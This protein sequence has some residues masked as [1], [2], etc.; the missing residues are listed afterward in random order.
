[1]EINKNRNYGVDLLRIIA[2]FMICM[3]HM[4]KR[5]GIIDNTGF[6][7]LEYETAWFFE[8]A[9]I[10]AV[11]IYALISGFIG[12]KSKHTV[13]SYVRLWLTVFFIMLISTIFYQIYDPSTVVWTD[14]VKVFFPVSTRQYWYFSSFTVLFLFL[15]LIKPAI[16]KLSQKSFKWLIISS[17]IFFSLLNTLFYNNTFFDPLWGQNNDPFGLLDG[18]SGIWLIELFL[19]G[20]YFGKYGFPKFLQKKYGLLFYFGCVMIAWSS[21]IL[22]EY[23]VNDKNITSQYFYLA[24]YT[25]PLIVLSSIGLL[26]AFSQMNIKD[27]FKK[28][29]AF[30]APSMFTVYI[31]QT[32]PLLWKNF[33]KD[34]LISFASSNVFVIVGVV[35][36]A[37]I[38]IFVA[39]V[40]ID[41]ILSWIIKLTKIVDGVKKLE[42]KLKA[43]DN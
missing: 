33:I 23:L 41:K 29:I 34:L 14:W 20:A 12:Y 19:V 39:G 31:V 37:S 10:G 40:I 22:I 1:M 24:S 26:A 43:K 16:E 38:C 32:Q 11:N 4:L 42:N 28:V 25:S 27:P 3:L 2:T 17:L 6:M 36:L 8:T 21:R 13:S 5:G 30:L 18:Y 15:P 35:F 7:S 9:C